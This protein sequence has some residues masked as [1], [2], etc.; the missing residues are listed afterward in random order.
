[1]SHKDVWFVVG[2]GGLGCFEGWLL[3][4]VPASSALGCWQT[5]W[6]GSTPSRQAMRD[7]TCNASFLSSS[8][9]TAALTGGA[10]PRNGR[11]TG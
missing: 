6:R 10:G 8:R 3:P 2:L 9:T 7:Y 11:T 5:T 1:M 4:V